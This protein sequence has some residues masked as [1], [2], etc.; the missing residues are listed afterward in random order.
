MCV[1][2][3]GGGGTCSPLPIRP[4]LRPRL[5]D[6]R[7]WLL[8]LHYVVAHRLF[9]LDILITAAAFSIEIFHVLAGALTCS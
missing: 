4:L 9:R 7:S 5:S 6:W 2:G 8:T 3:G 1:W